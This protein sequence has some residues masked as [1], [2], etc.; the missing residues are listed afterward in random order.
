MAKH[1]E[2]FGLPAAGKT[3]LLGRLADITLPGS[4]RMTV[5]M[6]TAPMSFN[7]YT[8]KFMQD[9]TSV[10]RMLLSNSR[11]STQLWHACS[12]FEHPTTTLQV[13]QF[14]NVLRL[15]SFT[16]RS[17]ARR[18]KDGLVVFDQGVFQAIWSLVLQARIDDQDQVL[19]K[20]R[21]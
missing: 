18:N 15:E 2:L 3:T 5:P 12:A 17:F 6:K 21:V 1:L 13:R 19:E 16:R 11:H 20:S 4:A 9:L 14:I 10:L 8:V 7:D